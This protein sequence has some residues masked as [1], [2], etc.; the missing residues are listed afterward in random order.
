MSTYLG[1][2]ELLDADANGIVD[3]IIDFLQANAL[4]IVNMV[5]IAT[6]GA[7]VMVGRQHSVYT[8]LKQRQPNLQLIR[9]V[10]HSLDI[11][12]QKA[13]QQLPSNVEYMIRET[14]NWFAH[15]SKHQNDYRTLYETINNGGCP[16][17][18]LSPSSTRWLVTANCIDR[19]LEQEYAL[20]L[21]FSVAASSEHCYAARLLSEMYKDKTNSLYL[22]FLRPLLLEIKSV[23]TFFQLETGDSLAV[24]RDLNRLYMST[25]RRIIKPS[26]FRMNNEQ[27]L[28]ELDLKSSSIY[29]LPKDADLGTTFSE[30]LEASTLSPEK[31]QVV[32]TLCM[33]LVKE[34]LTQYQMRLPASLELLWKLELLCPASVMSKKSLFRELPKKFF[35]GSP[36]LLETQWRNVACAGSHLT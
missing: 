35:S 33:D 20:A 2:V 1:L 14:Y 31:K 12:A 34:L 25:L 24:F 10:C 7:S 16:L 8:L 36:D 32:L 28:R 3:A 23:N 13:M 27:Q 26:V 19:I 29:L 11:V 18:M 6:D 9:C 22:H 4:D 21:H 30:K 15:S 5:D 17:K